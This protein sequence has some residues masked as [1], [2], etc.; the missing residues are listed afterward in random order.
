MI[1]NVTI[2]GRLTADPEL[3]ATNNGTSV[4]SFSIAVDRRFTPAGSDKATDFINCV[5]WRGTAE[6]IAKYFRKGDMIAVTGEIQTRSYTD[7]DGNKRTAVEVVIA[8]ASFCGSKN[9]RNNEAE[10]TTEAEYE[11]VTNLYDGDL[12]F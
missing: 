4:T 2:M 11:D 6:F 9:S 8:N 1:N 7:R 3:K 5:A 12:P 10:E